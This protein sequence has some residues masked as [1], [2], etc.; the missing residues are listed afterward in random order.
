PPAA[1]PSAMSAGASANAEEQRSSSE[2]PCPDS[3]ADDD[4][5]RGTAADAGAA[6]AAVAAQDRKGSSSKS[7]RSKVK[8]LFALMDMERVLD[9]AVTESMAAQERANPELVHYRDIMLDFLRQ[10][11]S[12]KSL[13]KGFVED[14]ME[15]F[16][17]GEIDDMIAFYKTPTGTKAISAVPSL[18]KRGSERGM[19]QVEKHLPELQKKI[20]ARVKER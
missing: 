17:E 8:E 13:E 10:Y 5:P 15:T 7:H 18:L 9:A 12:W 6:P 19:S 14:Y 4:A 3:N 2:Q 20:V 16:S 1:A 11:M